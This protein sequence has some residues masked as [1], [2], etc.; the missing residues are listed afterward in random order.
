[1][2]KVV[3]DTNVFISALFWKGKPKQVVELALSR[4]IVG[5][6][7]TKILLELKKK[8]IEKFSYP[9]DQTEQYL[10]IIAKECLMVSPFM[11]INIVTEDSTDNKIVEAAVAGNTDY[12]VTGDNHLL[13]IGSYRGIQ[14]V[15]P[16]KLI[17]ILKL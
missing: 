16:N 2:I 12:I 11:K 13:K 4:K 3:F 9:L 10:Q 1:M 15:T 14:I 5:V 8:L 7:S 17:T 6:T